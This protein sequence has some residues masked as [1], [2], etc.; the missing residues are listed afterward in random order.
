MPTRGREA[1]LSGLARVMGLQIVASGGKGG[2][3]VPS[4]AS[5][6]DQKQSSRILLTFYVSIGYEE[7]RRLITTWRGL[8][9]RSNPD[10][11]RTSSIHS[12]LEGPGTY[13]WTAAT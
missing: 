2:N 12:P 8:L 6:E 7:Q 11:D 3:Q 9:K 13:G 10:R 4:R 5:V 1:V